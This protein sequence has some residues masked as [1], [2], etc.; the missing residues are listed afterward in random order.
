MRCITLHNFW[1]DVNKDAHSPGENVTKKAK[2]SFH[3]NRLCGNVNVWELMCEWEWI[4]ENYS[5]IKLS[6][7]DVIILAASS[8]VGCSICLGSS[9]LLSSVFTACRLDYLNKKR[10]FNWLWSTLHCNSLNCWP[11]SKCI[12]KFSL[13]YVPCATHYSYLCIEPMKPQGKSSTHISPFFHR[14]LID[15]IFIFSSFTSSGGNL[16][17]PTSWCGGNKILIPSFTSKGVNSSATAKCKS[18][19]KLCEKKRR[20]KQAGIK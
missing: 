17:T 18:I 9:S 16:M 10:H 13:N 20:M 11:Y 3:T 5:Q 15:H 7:C 14:I 2:K 8:T 6:F 19:P 1:W 12:G 4:K